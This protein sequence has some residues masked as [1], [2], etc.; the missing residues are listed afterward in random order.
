MKISMWK[1]SKRIILSFW[2]ERSDYLR[3]IFFKIE[4]A[5]PCTGFDTLDHSTDVIDNSNDLT[6]FSCL[7]LASF[8]Y[9]CY[10][11]IEFRYFGASLSHIL[12]QLLGAH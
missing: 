1:F 2:L 7:S 5:H 4:I 8:V 11:F 6:F 3:L 9:L 10:N 12:E